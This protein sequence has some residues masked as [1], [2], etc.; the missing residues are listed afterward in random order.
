MLDETKNRT[1]GDVYLP[2]DSSNDSCAY[3][4]PSDKTVLKVAMED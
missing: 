4:H 3:I 1:E 2:V